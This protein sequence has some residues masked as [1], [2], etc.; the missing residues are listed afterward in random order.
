[1]RSPP[2]IDKSVLLAGF[3]LA[4][5]CSIVWAEVPGE[6]TAVTLAPGSNTLVISTKGDPGKVLSSVIARP[7]RLVMDFTSAVVGK[8]SLKVAGADAGIHAVRAAN[9]KAK[10]RVVA[11]FQDLPVPEFIVKREK[12]RVLV[13]LGE[14]DPGKKSRKRAQGSETKSDSNS[15]DSGNVRPAAAQHTAPQNTSLRD[16]LGEGLEPV[17]PLSS[18]SQGVS[19]HG[20]ALTPTEAGRAVRS[21][22]DVSWAEPAEANS[23]KP[24]D[25]LDKGEQTPQV[26]QTLA[27]VAE[28]SQ[29]IGK[30]PVSIPMRQVQ[31]ADRP[32]TVRSRPLGPGAS[33]GQTPGSGR[34][35]V[36]ENRPPITPPEPDPRLLVQELTEMKF[37]QVGHNSRLMIRGGDHL[38]YRIDRISQTKLK[39]DLINAEIPKSYQKPLR[40]DLFSTSVEMIIPGSQTIFIQLKEPAPYKVEKKKGVLMVDF[41]PPRFEL[42]AEMKAAGK[43]T[44]AGPGTSRPGPATGG[45]NIGPSADV[46]GQEGSVDCESSVDCL[47][48][49]VEEWAAERDKRKKYGESP[50]S[51][52]LEK[53]VTMD[54][55]DIKLKNAFRLLSEQAAVNITLDPDV[56]G[57]TT[58]SL[59]NVPLKDVINTML[60][61]NDLASVMV[62]DVMRIG[63]TKKINEFLDENRSKIQTLDQ[64]IAADRNKIK[65]LEDRKRK[66]ENPTPIEGS[67]R[68]DEI[69]EAGC[70]KVGEE[71]ICFYYATVRLTYAKP[72]EIVKTL[73]CMFNLNCPGT[74][75]AGAG[76]NELAGS[77][78]AQTAKRDST[79]DKEK[80]RL[81]DQ[82]FSPDSPG[83]ISRM[84]GFEALDLDRQRTDAATA[85][86]EAYRGRTGLPHDSASGQDR[87]IKQIIAN[88]ML[89]PDDLNRMIF[90]KD[91]SERISQM[92]KVLRSLDVPTPQVMIE[93]RL[94]R[95]SR[96]WA[97]EL[98]I[99]W[100]GRNNQNG[101]I[102]NSK[103]A[104]WGITGHQGTP[105]LYGANTATGQLTAG[106]DIPSRFAV[107]LP[108]P[109][110]SSTIGL[111][112][113]LGMQ[114]GLLGTQYITELDVRLEIGEGT[115]QL[116]IIARPKVQVLDGQK[117][118]ILDG[119]DV[120]FVTSSPLQGTQTQLVP[121]YLELEVKPTIY[122]D[123]RIS[124]EV[125][126]KDDDLGIIPLGA[127]LPEIIRRQATTNMIVRDGETAVIGGIVKER[128]HTRRE[129]W[130]GLMNVPLIG[131]FFSNKGQEKVMDELLVFITPTIVKR[132]PGAS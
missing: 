48:K 79:L 110:L 71:E 54:F 112:Q 77:V 84:M 113:G 127:T 70:I 51:D 20:R 78:A 68:S 49:R 123:G 53:T 10:A 69:G 83:G 23:R 52:I 25:P 106:N 95:A 24:Q 103:K 111:V 63:K 37:I 3:I 128:N 55:Q 125:K 118:K 122:S 50:S 39:L 99:R 74:G 97:R 126:V 30:P 61:T 58:L 5:F 132:P 7:N 120:P 81:Q 46:Q 22:S 104:F 29:R 116:K 121:A 73:D 57:K 1:M 89:W 115:N 15:P 90:V 114:F 6:I 124:M 92:K 18:S 91:T 108:T 21:T 85:R 34:G 75:Q 11:D 33:S 45:G 28:S 129:G 4:I 98:G 76:A 35:A 101:Q 36:R 31:P 12:D 44:A 96:E 130:P 32:E 64:R 16:W 86:T 9:Y 131:V 100:G 66:A 119:R 102:D 72:K 88:S 87:R 17:S 43:P 93:S 56:D 82:G 117:A 19:G 8:I 47:K 2:T 67:I 59:R 107:N 42:T 62:G 13:V 109:I 105:A 65:A 40:T 38:D 14:V 26:E 27:Q 60:L 80:T 41:S 94:V